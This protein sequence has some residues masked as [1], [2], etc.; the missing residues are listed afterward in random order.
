MTIK[1]RATRSTKTHTIKYK[2]SG[3]SGNIMKLRGIFKEFSEK[4]I[5]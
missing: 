2:E 1:D 5:T 3:K 4:Q